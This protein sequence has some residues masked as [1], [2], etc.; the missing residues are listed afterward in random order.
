MG[1]VTEYPHSSKREACL[2]RR[3]DVMLTSFRWGDSMYDWHAQ[4]PAKAERFR[5]A[6]RGVARCK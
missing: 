5:K 6:M 2:A 1:T 3:D 4:R